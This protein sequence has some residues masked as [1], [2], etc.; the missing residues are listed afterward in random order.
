LQL[1]LSC[2]NGNVNHF[3]IVSMR[4]NGDQ[5]HEQSLLPRGHRHNIHEI[6][7]CQFGKSLHRQHGCA[8]TWDTI[9]DRLCT[10]VDNYRLLQSFRNWDMPTSTPSRTFT[11]K[12]YSLQ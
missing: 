5:L 4:R 8:N 7:R 11:G 10:L 12:H 1:C 3:P 9:C 6:I 2:G